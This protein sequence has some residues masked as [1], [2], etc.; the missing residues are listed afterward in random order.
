MSVVAQT[1][2][3]ATLYEARQKA[4]ESAESRLAQ[5]TTECEGA[6]RRAAQ[7]AECLVA[8]RA[9]VLEQSREELEFARQG[10]AAAR[11]LQVGAAYRQGAEL[12]LQ[13]LS[14]EADHAM[15]VA[16]QR[17]ALLEQARHEVVLARQELAIVQRHR[18]AHLEKIRKA[19]D[20]RDDEQAAE[21]W[22]ANHLE[23]QTTRSK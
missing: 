21:V 7:A 19:A 10:G 16:A 23:L 5:R 11:D 17:R 15:A 6:E 1:Y 3:L 9:H 22:Q 14:R 13:Q 8:A 20:Q 2:P 18:D 12:R 4:V